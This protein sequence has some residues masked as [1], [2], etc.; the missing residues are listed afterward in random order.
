MCIV[1]DENNS[2]SE[3]IR[4]RIENNSA[5]YFSNDNISSFIEDGEINP[6]IE[7]VSSKMEAV[8]R[9]LVID[10]DNDHNTADTAKRVAKMFI[11][12]IF[13]GRYEKT[14]DITSFPN[15]MQYD[16]LYV[17]GPI[18]IR[19]MCAHHMM[20]IAG[21][22]YIGVHP[23]ANVIGLSKFNRIVDWI[24]SRPQIQEEM[25][26]QIA[27][28]IEK[29]TQ[30]SGVAV[31]IQAEHFCMTHRGVKEHDSDMTTSIVR[32]SFREDPNLKSEFFNI[33]N[34]MK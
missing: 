22:C 16:Q 11:N 29:I 26:Q 14:P 17:T 33:L 31:L 27:D 9:S 8:L 13:R 3:I 20:P 2:V 10:I 7:E 6:L 32:G 1:C 30:A 12:E 28:E 4:K 18:T 5:S 34:R 15:V 25:T 24:A 19:S 21:K 23:G